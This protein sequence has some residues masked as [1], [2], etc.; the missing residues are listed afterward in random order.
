[1]KKLVSSLAFCAI[2]MVTS[3]QLSRIVVQ[4]T[5][6]PQ[7]FS[8]LAAAITAAQSNDYLYLSGGTF[9]APDNLVLD[10]PLHFVGA[11]MDPDSTGITGVTSIQMIWS[12][13]PVHYIVTT[14]ASGSSFTGIA[15][16]GAS[17]PFQYGTSADDDDPTGIMF[18]RC[19]FAA[20]LTLSY[21]STT[22]MSSTTFDECIFY[23]STPTQGTAL[24]TRCIFSGTYAPYNFGS[25]SPLTMRHCVCIG[26]GGISGVTGGTFE[27]CIFNGTFYGV[28]ATFNNCL[29]VASGLPPGSTGS[30]NV[31]SL[32][33][34]SV[35]VNETD[36]YYQFADDLHLAVGSIGLNAATDGTD[37]GLYGSNSPYKMGAVP[38]APHYQL[39]NIGTATNGALQLPVSFK[40]AAQTH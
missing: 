33:A 3:A 29:F 1:M 25:G 31:F 11:G 27:D 28:A 37:V 36:G 34:N 12:G 32:T 39:A 26:T 2:A 13:I 4:G 19:S 16:G 14:A 40:V 18:Q 22:A 21:E 23:N 30:G 7:V 35:F 6:G 5:G 20:G 8:D 17:S 24:L 9:N 15:F 10:K 38:Y